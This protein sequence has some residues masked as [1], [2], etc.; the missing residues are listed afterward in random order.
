MEASNIAKDAFIEYLRFHQADITDLR[1]A[2]HYLLR[3][4]SYCHYKII[5]GKEDLWEAGTTTLLGGVVLRLK[6]SKEEKEKTKSDP[7]VFVCVSIGDCKAY[8]FSAKSKTVSDI[9][10]GNRRVKKSSYIFRLNLIIIITKNVHDAR[11]PGGR[12]GPYVGEGNPDLRNTAGRF[13]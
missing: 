2:G 4:L 1:D 7:Y 5:E 13:I 6:R 9:T 3:A 8:L 10:A 11:D 12:L